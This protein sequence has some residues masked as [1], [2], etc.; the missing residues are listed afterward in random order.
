MIAKEYVFKSKMCTFSNCI[1]NIES[2]R[3]LQNIGTRFGFAADFDQ[4]M[5]EQ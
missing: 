3:I 2:W 1:T 4:H 5:P